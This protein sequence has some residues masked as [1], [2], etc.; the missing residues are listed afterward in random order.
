MA[1]RRW[2]DLGLDD[3]YEGIAAAGAI[4]EYLDETQKTAV[5]HIT[6]I[7]KIRHTEY[8]QIDQTTLR[9]LEVLRTMRS[10]DAKGTLLG[11]VDKTL[12]GMGSRLM[13]YWICMPLCDVGNIR[14]R[15]DAVQELVEDD[16]LCADIRGRL[17]GIFDLERIV[18]RVT[19]N[20]AM[21]R[22]LVALAATL[23]TIP[24]LRAD[25]V[26]MS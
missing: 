19:T 14:T 17:K 12:T 8:L 16:S 26:R 15:Q 25:I 22:D 20:R 9:S 1:F 6:S 11:C 7:K 23:R 13:R 24:T 3:S 10:E 21:P 4:L 2:R 18:A 5:K